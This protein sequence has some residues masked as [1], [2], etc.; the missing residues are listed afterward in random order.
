MDRK[1]N[2]G[3]YIL[4]SIASSVCYLNSLNCGFVFDDVSAVKENRDLR[5][6]TPLL[7]LFQ[8]DF[9]GTPIQKE[10]SHKSYRPL[11]V[12]TFRLNYLL[13]GLQPMGY[14]LVNVLFHVVVCLL[15]FR[16][17][18]L[19]LPEVA[20]VVSSLLFAVHPVHTEAVT[21]VV[22]RAETL[23]S[24]FF[25][26]AFLCYVKCTRPHQKDYHKTDWTELLKCVLLIAVATLSKEQGITVTAV[27]CAYDV[28]VAQ[29]LHPADFFHV[30]QLL[31][32][33]KGQPPP[34]LREMLLRI[35]VLVTSSVL[36]LMARLK[37]MGAQ[38]PVFTKFDNPAA[39]A[40]SPTKQLT[41]NYL[42]P[43]NAWLLLFPHNLCCDW[44]MGTIPLLNSYQ[45]VRN[46]A[47]VMFYLTLLSLVWAAFVSEEGHLVIMSLALTA[48][49]FLPASNLFF[50]V[51]FVVAERVL[52]AP[53]MGFFM[54]VGYGWS[55]IY[56]L[57][58]DSSNGNIFR[59]ILWGALLIVIGIH[60]LKTFIRNYDWSS[61]YTLFMSG[62]KVNQ[63]NAKLYNNVGHALESEGKYNE[64][65]EY[66][67]TA[68]KVQP[69]DLGAHMNIG[70]TYNNLGMY[71]D[72]E[73]AFWK[74]KALLPKARPGEPY[75]TRIA[76]NHL[77]VF[78]NLANLISRNG[79][80]LEEADA[81]YRQAISMRADYVQA[82]INRGDILIKMNRSMEAK[83]VYEKALQ[84]DN[85]NP[86]IYYNLGVVFLEQ[87][88]GTQA[89]VYFEKALELDPDHEQALMNSAILIQENGTPIMRR[90][91]YERL[92]LLIKKG[93]GNE[94]VYFNLG[95]L[96]MDDK[97]IEHAESWF[98]K[99]I[100]I[101]DDFRSALFNLALLLSDDKKPLESVT[102]LKQLLK[103]HPDHIKGLILLGD[104]YINH[105]KDLDEAEAC[106]NKILSLDPSNIQATHNLCVV[107]VE[108]GNL[109]EGEKC[110][111]KAASLAP[112]E[113]YIQRHLSIVRQ[114]IEKLR[115]L[116][117]AA[118]AKAS[119]R[120]L[121]SN[122]DA[123]KEA[124]SGKAGA[125]VISTNR[126]SRLSSMR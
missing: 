43:V 82:Y 75:Q 105:M 27:C 46:V 80:R 81:L 41:F 111:V 11:C 33:S 57:L 106:Y 117:A 85:S 76:P 28:F 99:A 125:K 45:D 3:Y 115:E 16:V 63:W 68:A 20:S 88:K 44:T 97:R 110:L 92:I 86:D 39:T 69:D 116:S 96:S 15:Y 119:S 112:Y 124:E 21:G 77:N 5:P 74:A 70:R 55:R 2:L 60:A 40:E 22:G 9:W 65:L 98:K 126:S 121:K 114:R 35:L 83:E 87:N 6:N 49:P 51:G 59:Q 4:I 14:H 66:F 79:S 109:E 103:Y 18:L 23:S 101:R 95:M 108:R 12:L 118:R 91:A 122:V 62:I 10:H 37:I 94:R 32:S 26:W 42:L 123:G 71:N 34:W 61:E 102:Y 64:A 89:L 52:Y 58:Q 78:L 100:K 17:C 84:F 50:P 29:G 107:H 90:V 56:D 19:F 93:K 120:T 73:K 72:A 67:Q 53:S 1:G 30:I 8:N 47:T 113:E 54:L 38:L 48:F 31:L 13:H 7:E 36:L 104:I 25:L 24:V